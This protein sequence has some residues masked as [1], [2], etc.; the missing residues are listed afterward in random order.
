MNFPPH[1]E[2][3]KQLGVEGNPQCVCATP[4]DTMA[5]PWGHVEGCHYPKEC[6]AAMCE[7]FLRSADF[8]WYERQRYYA[9]RF[10]DDELDEDLGDA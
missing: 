3:A 7:H 2:I 8:A 6:S 1:P 4:I 10:G 9:D 5:C